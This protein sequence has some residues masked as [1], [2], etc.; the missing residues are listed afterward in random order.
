MLI[1]RLRILMNDDVPFDNKSVQDKM[2]YAALIKSP[3]IVIGKE[4][5]SSEEIDFL[6]SQ[7]FK[8][9]DTKVAKNQCEECNNFITISGW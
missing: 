5:V 6:K 2:I 9:E 1:D 7:G 8:V 3:S 4:D